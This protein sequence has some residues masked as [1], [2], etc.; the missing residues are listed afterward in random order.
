MSDI[1]LR[2]TK[3]RMMILEE[4]QKTFEHPSAFEIYEKV[5]ESLPHISLGTVYRNLEILSAQGHIKKLEMV[6]GQRRFD[7]GMQDHSHILCVSCGRL[8]D[9]PADIDAGLRTAQRRVEDATGFRDIG[10]SVGF[11]GLCPDCYAKSRGM[12]KALKAKGK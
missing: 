7:A 12:H 9:V 6:P 8:D 10:W 5:R 11:H 2:M 4:M 1:K 3:Q